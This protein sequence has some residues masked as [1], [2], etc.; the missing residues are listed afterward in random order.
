MRVFLDTNVLVSAFATRGLCADLLRT[1]LVE[2]D[3]VT[4]EVVLAELERVL[5]RRFGYPPQTIAAVLS[6]LR[7]HHV[8][9]LPEELP[10]I[11]IRDPDALVVL[12]SALAG[13]AEVLVTGDQDLLSVSDDVAIVVTNPRGFLEMLRA[14][15]SS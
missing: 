14:Q 8:Q 11:E 15:R 1:V 2:H 9:P 10:E 7:Q 4:A 12:A 5:A 6:L 3:L 13:G